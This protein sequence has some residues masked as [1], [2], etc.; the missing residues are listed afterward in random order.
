[1][2]HLHL[3]AAAVPSAQ[4]CCGDG[5]PALEAQHSGVSPTATNLLLNLWSG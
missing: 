5:S 2:Q 4:G 1:M 3:L